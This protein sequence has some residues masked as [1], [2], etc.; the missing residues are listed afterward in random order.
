MTVGFFFFFCT[1]YKKVNKKMKSVWTE[2]IKIKSF[3]KLEK[4]IKTDVLIIGGGM[5]G[6]LT[7]YL[8]SKNNLPLF[9]H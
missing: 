1:E 9:F 7:A 4:D 2:N 6:I 5:A 3:P 8:L